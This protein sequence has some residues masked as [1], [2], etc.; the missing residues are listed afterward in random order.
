MRH[1]FIA[2]LIALLPLRGWV[3]D[4]MATEM[5]VA[6]FQ[7]QQQG[8]TKATVEHAH[9]AGEQAH[10][11]PDTVVATT[12]LAVADCPG[13][14]SGGD[15]HAAD[16]H[17]ESCSVCQVCHTVALSA[18]PAGVAA[19]FSL[20]IVLRAEVAQFASAPAARGQ[21]PPIS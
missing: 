16:T 2:F 19:V 1:L 21:K 15:S 5:V 3:S 17:C 8:A 13:H 14:A 18:A 20:G 9:E 4:A 10:I 6:Q 12:S 11:D 7:T